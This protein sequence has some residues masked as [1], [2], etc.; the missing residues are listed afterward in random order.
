MTNAKCAKNAAHWLVYEKE[1][2]KRATFRRDCIDFVI[3][4]WRNQTG[5]CSN[6][7]KIVIMKYISALARYTIFIIM[8]FYH[9]NI[10][11]IILLYILYVYDYCLLHLL[12][13]SSASR[14]YRRRCWHSF[15]VTS[16]DSNMKCF[17]YRNEKPVVLRVCGKP[18][19]TWLFI[20]IFHLYG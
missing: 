11:N 14:W 19:G 18:F 13:S 8:S 5:C 20:C 3:A 2:K 7:D 4:Y 17:I 16:N 6:D 1:G 12:S 10:Y 9:Y 15:W